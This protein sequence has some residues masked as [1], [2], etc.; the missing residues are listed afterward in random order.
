VSQPL[1]LAIEPDLR[2]AAIVKRIV[3]EKALADVVV[4]DSRD[5]AIEAMRTSMPDVLLLSALLSPRDEDELMA[6]L[7]TLDH[8]G[9]LQTHTIPQL[10]STLDGGEERASRG[11]F[12]RKKEAT[13]VAG[14]DPDLFAEEVR[15]YLRH[16]A[17]KKSQLQSMPFVPKAN[18]P[19]SSASASASAAATA[20][21]DD[22]SAA[23]DSAWASPFEWKPASGSGKRAS[24]SREDSAPKSAPPPVAAPPPAPEPVVAAPAAPEPIVAAPMPDPI[25]AA[26]IVEA[27]SVIKPVE[28]PIAAA[29]VLVEAPAVEPVA[30]APV[31][32]PPAVGQ[33]L[34]A[35]PAPVTP[36]P[37]LRPLVAE[38]VG[39]LE[40]PPAPAP[41]KAAKT[42][43]PSRP[44]PVADRP[45]K[46]TSSQLQD[47]I[48]KQVAVER[49]GSDG[50]GPL[51]RWARSDAPR[52]A[53][54]AAVTSDDIR[55]LIA[56][57]AV[58]AA[59]ASVTYP[60]GVRLRR[61]RVPLAADHDG[62]V[63]ASA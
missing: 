36:P 61:V 16:A 45:A 3:R 53:K 48:R 46:L 41:K 57:L 49:I 24:R 15:T 50:L 60:T 7:K 26:P 47:L 19:G 33:T 37:V 62:A 63:Q 1:V 52:A 56:E 20:E 43:E 58:P 29:P 59:V 8:A 14:C 40:P 32:E 39:T 6:H 11:W 17:D 51:A 55:V 28:E 31:V 25:A 34:I 35:E 38:K 5:A 44:K 2:Q 21:P 18:R 23:P 13:Q 22:A 10:A 54:N 27:S 30:A 42:S 4:V 12:R 9:H